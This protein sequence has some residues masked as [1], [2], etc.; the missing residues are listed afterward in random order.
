MHADDGYSTNVCK[1]CWTLTDS[2]HQL[3]EL[4]QRSEANL[5]NNAFVNDTHISDDDKNDVWLNSPKPPTGNESIVDDLVCKLEVKQEQEEE[6]D[7]SACSSK[8]SSSGRAKKSRAKHKTKGVVTAEERKR[9]DER[10]EQEN[11]QIRDFFSMNCEMCELKFRTVNEASLHYKRKHNKAGYLTC[12]GRKFFRRCMA[13][14]HIQQ[15]LN[16]VPLK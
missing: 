6:S 12:C 16:P 9:R 8:S 4:V 10:L 14:E 5:T 11:Q 7:S 13:L 3:Y 2:F 1:R 15:H